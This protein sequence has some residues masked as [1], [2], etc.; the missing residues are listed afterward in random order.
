VLPF[1]EPTPLGVLQLVGLLGAAAYAGRRWWAVPVLLLLAG[2]YAYQAYF[3]LRLAATGHTGFLHY[4]N[5]LVG[6]LL[7]GAGAL[8]LA[9]LVPALASRVRR[10]GWPR[11]RGGVAVVALAAALAWAGLALWDELMPAPHG[12]RDAEA[13][14]GKR[15]TAAYAHAQRLPDGR[16][17]P[18]APKGVP[19][20]GFPADQVAA[21]IRRRLGGDAS[22][23]VLSYDQRLFAFHPF[24]GYVSPY[25]TSANSLQRWDE[26]AAAVRDL[27]SISDP[28]AFA[29]A[30]GSTPFGPVDVFVLREHAGAFGWMGIR[31]DPAAFAPTYFDVV[32]GLPNRTVVAIRGA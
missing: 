9:E 19:V 17:A 25:R 31:F 14:S 22:P 1:L 24:A 8:T 20:T 27:A 16:P 30:A 23:V 29:R 2:T 3:L 5:P 11:P 21:Q 10:A 32:R 4:A 18:R 26:R 15:N 6:A 13:V 12:L 28:A 7:L